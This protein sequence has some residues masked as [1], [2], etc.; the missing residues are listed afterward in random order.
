MDNS[1]QKMNVKVLHRHHYVSSCYGNINNNKYNR[2]KVKKC[3]AQNI[4]F[5]N[6]L[7]QLNKV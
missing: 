5:Q 4:H 1:H 7:F 6:K 2:N 3:K